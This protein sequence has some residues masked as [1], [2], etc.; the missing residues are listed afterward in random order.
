MN[1]LIYS[2]ATAQLT[3]VQDRDWALLPGG[4]IHST[5]REEAESTSLHKIR[6]DTLYLSTRYRNVILCIDSPLSVFVW[7]S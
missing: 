7:F 6:I 5:E 4:A 3:F 1:S 2:A